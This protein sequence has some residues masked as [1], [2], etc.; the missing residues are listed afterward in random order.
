MTDG[1]LV[2]LDKVSFGYDGVLALQDVDLV[3]RQGDFLAIIGPN[4]GGKTTLLECILGLRKPWR[5]TIRRFTSGRAGALGYVP[6]FARFDADFPLR[7][8]DVIAMG[9]LG[10]ARS[11]GGW[12]R[13]RLAPAERTLLAEI[14]DR[15]GL[16]HLLERP[17]GDL[18]GGQVQRVLTAR[19]LAAEPEILFLDEPLASVDAQHRKTLV[20]TLAELR[21][22]IPVVVVTHDLTP[23]APIVGQ[24]ACVNRTLHYHPEGRVSEETLHEVYGCPVELVAHGVPHRVLHEH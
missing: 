23:W 9:R 7:V 24:I 13:W 10:P 3:V 17:I 22:R 14:S 15:F 18:S 11:T 16:T 21:S 5:G 12:N 2:E 8:R 19:A 1:I 6:Q 20:D 4:G